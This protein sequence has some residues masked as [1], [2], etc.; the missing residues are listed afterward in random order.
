MT[1]RNKNSNFLSRAKG[2][3]SCSVSLLV[4]GSSTSWDSRSKHNPARTPIVTETK[5]GFTPRRCS[6]DRG[7]WEVPRRIVELG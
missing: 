6:H 5:K 7:G 1:Q 4:G 2:L 3:E